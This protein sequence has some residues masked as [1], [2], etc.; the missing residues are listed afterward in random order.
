MK[1]DVTH[2]TDDRE[3]EA[4]AVAL[5]GTQVRISIDTGPGNTGNGT[6]EFAPST[7]CAVL[8]TENSGDGAVRVTGGSEQ[9]DNIVTGPTRAP[10][11]W[12]IAVKEGQ[13]CTILGRP[14]FRYFYYQ[15]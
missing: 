2:I 7:V 9:I 11:I 12:I 8:V 4:E 10:R 5:L 1:V 6:Y 13:T 3:R 15:T 14:I